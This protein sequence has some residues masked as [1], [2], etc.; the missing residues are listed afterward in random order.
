[1]TSSCISGSVRVEKRGKYNFFVFYASCLKLCK[2]V[3]FEMLITKRRPKLKLE[4]VL[5]R[6][7]RNFLSIFAKIIPNTLQQIELPWQ[8]WMSHGTGLYSN[9]SLSEYSK[10]QKVS[11]SYCLPS[12]HSKGKNQRADSVHP[13]P[14]DLFSVKEIK[15][16]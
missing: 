1:M 11:A 10:S 2:G 13:P 6:K 8:K 3:N 5:R 16:N 4:N 9:E 14:P 15:N 12:Q 7:K